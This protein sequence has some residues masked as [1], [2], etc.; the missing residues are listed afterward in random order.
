LKLTCNIPIYYRY[1]D[2]ILIS[3]PKS[4]WNHILNTFNSFHERIQF[5]LELNNNNVLNFLDVKII[6]EDHR[7]LFDGYKKP[8]C[9]GRYLNFHSQQ[10]ITQKKSIIMSRNDKIVQL[11]HPRFQQRNLKDAIQIFLQNSYPLEFIFS[12]IRSRIKYLSNKS[13]LC[14]LKKS[15]PNYTTKKEYFCV[16]YI[17]T[18]SESLAPIASIYPFFSGT[19]FVVR[20]KLLLR[21][22]LSLPFTSLCFRF[23]VRQSRIVNI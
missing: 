16:P 5:I 4:H 8:T 21:I 17:N 3:A 18:V 13:P 7:I 9:S 1:V 10:P 23:F 15:N 12:T 22:H 14:Y 2:D 11:S 19:L 20:R 6:I